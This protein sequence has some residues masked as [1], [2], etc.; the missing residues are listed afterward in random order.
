M[1]RG[2]DHRGQLASITAG[3][4]EGN[5]WMPQCEHMYGES[6][7]I[8]G[9]RPVAHEDVVALLGGG[10]LGEERTKLFEER[11]D[12]HVRKFLAPLTSETLE[13]KFS[14]LTNGL[15]DH[16]D[17]GLPQQTE[18]AAAILA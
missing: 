13:K 14:S 6:D 16:G 9:W 5:S 11:L 10:L 2:C 18:S 3:K 8:P 4:G 12:Q 17:L 15:H 1:F 7:R